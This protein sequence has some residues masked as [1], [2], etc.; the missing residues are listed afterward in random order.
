MSIKNKNEG[1][2]LKEALSKELKKDFNLDK[3]KDKKLLNSNVKFKEQQWIPFSEALQDTLGIAGI[4]AGHITLLR[5]HSNTGKTTTLFETAIAG[6]KMGILPVFI[7]TEM[8]HSWQH[9]KEMGFEIEDVIDEST[10][11]VINHKGFFIYADRST[12]GTIEDIA[13]FILDLL[14]EQKKGNLPYDLLFLW[15]SIGSIPCKLSVESNNNNPQWNAGAMATQFGNFVNQRIGMSRKENQ[16]YTNTLVCVNKVGV[17]PAENI[18][19]QPKMTNKGGLTM[20][21]DASLVLTFGNVTNSGTSKLKA[22]RNGKDLEFA[23][24]TKVECTKN[25]VTS[26]TTK[27]TIISTA[28][29]FIK[30]DKKS[31][32]NYKKQYSKDWATTLGGVDFEIIED[33]SDWDE[34]SKI[35]H[36]LEEEN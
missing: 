27:G 31:I 18:F 5:G 20:F 35:N 2:S 17:A 19:S 14:D 33:S 30:D 9:L 24:K 34:S 15:D 32:D 11:E 3:F 12:L 7:I 16:P 36:M 1:A 25:H 26:V 21:F 29:G 23:V 10:G 8:K 4:P 22:K 6:Q 13:A 28:Y